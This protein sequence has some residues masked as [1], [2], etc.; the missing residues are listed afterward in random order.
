MVN[1]MLIGV[2]SMRYLHRSKSTT[3]TTIRQTG[4]VQKKSESTVSTAKT[5]N[6]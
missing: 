4:K 5:K 6:T 1:V 3:T 2:F